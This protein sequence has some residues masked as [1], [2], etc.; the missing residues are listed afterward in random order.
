M[1]S[2]TCD[3]FAPGMTPLHRAGL[4]GLASTLRWI[5]RKVPAAE[6]PPGQWTIDERSVILTWDGT[7]GAQ[8]FFARLFRLAFQLQEGLIYLPGQYGD[9][10]PPLEVRAALHEGLLLSLYDHGPTSRGSRPAEARTYEIDE[11]PISYKYLPLTW[12]K[13]QREGSA[14]FLDSLQGNFQLTRSV[15]PGAIERHAGLTGTHVTHTARLALP[16]LFA[17]VGVLA[18]KAGGKR[19]NDRGKRKFKPGAAL[20]V[21][22]LHDLS[23]VHFLLPTLLPKTARDCQIANVADAAL[24]AELRLR[25]QH[26]LNPDAVPAIRCVWCCPTDWNSRLQP[27]SL[28]TEVTI[29]ATDPRLDQFATAM[30]ALPPPLPRQNK[31]GEYFWPRSYVRPLVAENLAAGRPCIPGSPVS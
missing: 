9:L 6:R 27:P 28:V 31:K 20:L 26:L 21:L 14:L 4:G 29:D 13:H 16:L 25:S 19:V 5:E 8:P 12:Y 3:L 10:P 15:F 22:D 30:A 7:A 11:K 17:P 24:Q 2:L 23:S 1:E 18:L